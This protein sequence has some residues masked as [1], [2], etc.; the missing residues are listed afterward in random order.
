V[1]KLQRVGTEPVLV[2]RPDVPWEKDAVFNC[3]AI[4][5]DGRFRLHYRAVAHTPGDR[6]RS[7]IGYACSED[8][9]DF[10]RL[11]QPVLSPGEV[12]EESQGVEDPRVTRLGDAFY[13]L[14]TA[15]DRTRTQIG[16]ARS[17]DLRAWTRLGVAQGLDAFGN[18]KDAA[19]FPETIG[20]RY[21]MFHRPH[22]TMHV[23]FSDDLRHWDDHRLV[24]E[25]AFAWEASKIGGGAQPIRTDAGWLE[26][27]HGV[28]ENSVYR[29]GIVLLDLEDPSKVVKR[30]PEPILEPELPWE[31]EGDVPNVVFSCGA[32]LLGTELW[33]YY[34]GAD[35]V[36]GVAKGDV[37]EFLD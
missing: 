37:R 5:H 21:C 30:Q 27:Y 35:T 18:N 33:V 9:V 31:L 36:I 7:W 28:D 16:M 15:Y 4:H 25:P 22:P 1:L 19:L 11:D 14:Y 24:M 17:D 26:V 6:N 29:L 13:M 34:G 23:S 3:A 2:P 10:E 20:G 12:P 32:V 8:G